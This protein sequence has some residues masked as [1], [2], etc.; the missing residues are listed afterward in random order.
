MKYKIVF[1]A[2]TT[3]SECVGTRTF[4][5]ETTRE[6]DVDGKKMSLERM[7]VEYARLTGLKCSFAFIIDVTRK[8]D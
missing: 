2:L 6:L 4:T 3:N 7:C 8:E 1:N 5:I